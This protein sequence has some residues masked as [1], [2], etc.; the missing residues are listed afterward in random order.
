MEQNQ[1][2]MTA[3]VSAFCRAYHALYDSP[4]IF[5][6]FLA[7]DMLTDEQF[8]GISG[9]MAAGIS[10]FHPEGAYR[11]PSPADALRWVMQTQIAPHLLSRSRYAEERL[12]EA[13][14]AGTGQYVILGAGYDTFAYRHP[15]L[16]NRIRVFEVDHPATQA[17]KR[18]RIA[19]L[20][21]DIPP[22][23]TLVPVDFSC[24]G[25]AE[26]LT[27][28]GYDPGR[29]V[30]VSWLGVTYY[31]TREEILG[32]LRAIASVALPGSGIAFDYPDDHFFDADAPRRVRCTAAMA[33][34]TGEPMR[35]ALSAAEL[36]EILSQAG[37]YLKEH[38]TPADI[39]VR[40]FAG[41]SD[42]YRAFD[43]IH[44]ALAV[45]G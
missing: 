32:T 18:D 24:G 38:L 25:L 7:R 37:F 3:V 30:F 20:G 44:Y 41:R 22:S 42:A 13:I 26:A 28:A 8:E 2:S 17:A 10:F 12:M 1:A 21:W 9:H 4:K 14:D 16:M 11:Y 40:H 31:L 23:L 34:G 36:T 43:C 35:T 27:G 6:D 15:A 19:A 33:Q 29:P 39:D 5:D 45:R